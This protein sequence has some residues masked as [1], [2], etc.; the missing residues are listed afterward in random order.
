MVFKM[1][2][3]HI[4]SLYVIIPFFGFNDLIFNLVKELIGL[5]YGNKILSFN[6]NP[7]T[8]SVFVNKKPKNI[9]IYLMIDFAYI[10][11]DSI[12]YII[13]YNVLHDFDTCHLGLI[14]VVSRII[15]LIEQIFDE[16]KNI[17]FWINFFLTILL[18]MSILF[19]LE[20]LEI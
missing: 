18:L 10:V 3:S 6:N 17:L 15:F 7:V 13:Y 14:M 19:F 16:K 11:I 8:F 12:Y 1:G 9:F 2:V 5:K 4:I 20:I